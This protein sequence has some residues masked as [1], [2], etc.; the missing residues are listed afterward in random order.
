MNRLKALYP[1]LGLV[2]AGVALGLLARQVFGPPAEYQRPPP[3]I[4]RPIAEGVDV[5]AAGINYAPINLPVEPLNKN[6]TKP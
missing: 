6:K 1:R 5:E 2:V 4:D 3:S